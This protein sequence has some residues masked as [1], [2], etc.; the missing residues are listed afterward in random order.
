MKDLGP[1]EWCL[2]MKV[3]VNQDKGE[4]TIS[5]AQHAR[6]VVKRFDFIKKTPT[7][8]PMDTN[9]HLSSEPDES[10]HDK[11][12][13]RKY[14]YREVIGSLMYITTCTRP[15]LAFAVCRL[16]R[17]MSNSN[18]IA[19]KAA[20]RVLQYLNCTNHYQLQ[21]KGS[22]CVIVEYADADYGG[23]PR[24]LTVD[25]WVSILLWKLSNRMGEQTTAHCSTI[26]SRI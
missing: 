21:Y 14:P 15:D 4:V 10:E 23:G 7:S 20:N 17:F 22:T 25:L 11:A 13:T 12:L 26:L 5:Q 24:Y 16:A 9:V 1:V 2:G 6:N 8:T 3:N 18:A 19:C